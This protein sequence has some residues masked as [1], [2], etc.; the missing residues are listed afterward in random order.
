MVKRLRFLAVAFFV[1]L[2]AVVQAQVTTSSMSGRVTDAEGA[3]IGATVVATHVPSGTTYG[4][5]TN[6]EGRYNLNGM[7]VGGPYS[8]EVTYIGYGK[9]VAEN[10]TLQLGQN[11]VHNVE[12]REEATTLG[13]VVV[14]AFRNPILNSDRTGA[15]TNINST[16]INRM[17]TVQRS[18]TDFTRLTPQANGNGFAGRDGRY[19]NLQIDGANFNNAFGLSSNALPGGESQPIS[20]D[21]IEEVSV[22]IAPYDVRQTGFTGAGVNAVTRSGT[23]RIEGSAY[24]Y[25]RPKSFSG[26]N[27]G[28]SKL[29]AESRNESQIYGARIGA[30]IIKNKLFFFGNFEYENTLSSGNNWLAARS[31][32]SGPNVTRVNAADLDA[33]SN[34]L[35]SEYDYDPGRYENYANN[36]AVENFKLLAKIDWNINDN[37]KM[38]LRFNTMKGTS[39]QGTNASSGPNPRSSTSRI[40]SN[41]IAFENANYN[42]T[43]VVT[44]LTGEL[45]SVLSQSLSNQFLATYS[46]IQDT[47]STPGDIFPMVDIWKDGTNYMT[48]GTELFS[49]NNEVINDNVSITNNLVYLAGSH[50]ITGGLNFETKSFANSYM[51][52]GTSYYRY[53]SVESF[54][55]GG[56]PDVFGIT[57]AYEGKDSFARV[58]F[59]TGGAY[60]QDKFAMSPRFNLTAGLRVDI[61][62]FLDDPYDNPEV[63]KIELLDIDGN[64][65]F[66]STGKWPA[67]KLLLSPRLGFNWDVNG[68]RSLQV[69]G[70][71]GIFTGNIPFVWFT[72]MP[73]NSGMIQNTF[74]PVSSATL[75]KITSFNPDPLY[76]VKQ[77]PGDFPPAPTAAPGSF[78]VVASDFKMPSIWRSSLGADLRIPELPLIVTADFIYSKDINAVYQFNANRKPATSQMAY[79]NDDRDLWASSNDAKY[80]AATGSIIPVLTNT[81]K[82]YSTTATIGLTLQETA[83]LSGSLFYT[84]FNAQDITGNPGS[85]ANSAWSNNYSVNDPNEQ[86]M[87]YSQFAVPHRIVGNLSYRIAYG[88]NLASTFSLFYSGSHQGRFAYTYSND[89]NQDGVSMDLLY[90]PENISELTFADI[91]NKDGSVVF[92]AAQQAEAFD[93][94]VDAHKELKD[95]RGGYVERNAGLMPWLNRWDFKFMQDF[96]INTGATRHNLQVTLD[97]LNVGNLLNKDWGLLK[98]LNMGNDY[99][100]GIL[101]RQ[102][103]WN[104]SKNRWDAVPVVNGI[105]TVQMNTVTENGKAI[106]PTTPFRDRFSSSSTWSMQLGLRYI[107]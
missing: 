27:V 87:G 96:Y 29:S 95:A 69:R 70:G 65:T 61:P 78:A 74:E 11:Y 42:F 84:Y 104:A 90:V 52:M 7:R 14:T 62:F 1:M 106:L 17:P 56:A 18:I 99:A 22:N 92:T 35:K 15:S 4:T 25:L 97:I 34:H 67:S 8:V 16:T 105:P 41:S 89:F 37:H 24:T 33:V 60:I 75:A 57:Y 26:L 32:V 49:Y 68:D 51:R 91:L 83:G 5:V 66:Y 98:Q 3:V 59:A 73:T 20:L 63:E 71:T 39:D 48:F 38:T 79:G 23:N 36:Y 102:E 44:S 21:A 107:F 86:L 93:A 72:N 94:F 46:R 50:T 10:L 28:D 85:A 54:L 6:L 13:E 31:G 12:L 2:A 45:N 82:G 55:S 53:G 47:R 19:N 40:S 64:K 80:N 30:P 77:L 100:Y 76:W 9:S 101:K 58:K 103:V 43:N 81:D 88:R